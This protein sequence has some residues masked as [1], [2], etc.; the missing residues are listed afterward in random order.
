M[1]ESSLSIDYTELVT[2][3]CRCIGWTG[4]SA[5]LTVDEQARVD[6]IIKN[7]LRRFYEP[8]IIPGRSE[9]HEWSFLKPITSITVFPNVTGTVSGSGV[10]DGSSK[11]TITA[12]SASFYPTMEGHDFR[13]DTSM[14]DYE[15]TDYDSTTQIKV[16]GNASGEAADDT[17]TITTT[18]RYR[19]PDDYRSLESELTFAVNEGY[20]PVRITSGQV[21][22]DKEQYGPTE[23]KP[24]FAAVVPVDSDG[25]L[26]QR[27]NLA[28]WPTPDQPY[29]MTF[30]MGALKQILSASYP[31]PLGGASHSETIRQACLMVA[32]EDENDLSDGPH[33][34][35]YAKSLQVSVIADEKAHAAK[36]LGYNDDGRQ[37]T[38]TRHDTDYYVY[39]DGTLY[40]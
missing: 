8:Q 27:F 16:S 1:A 13:F 4:D 9:P 36:T 31:Y 11:T 38:V 28:V 34:A 18:R 25:A 39:K 26:G 14:T 15:I 3:V 32:D 21:I 19:L 30:R 20:Q 37:E 7:G 40:D 10:Y 6:R 12:T 5:N 23:G 2:E 33:H 29:V 22:R 24:R 17:F 35:A